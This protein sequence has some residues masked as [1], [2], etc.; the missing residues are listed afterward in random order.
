MFTPGQPTPDEKQRLRP[1]TGWRW[2]LAR[3][4]HY[5]HFTV[6]AIAQLLQHKI[7]PQGW[8]K[9]WAAFWWEHQRGKR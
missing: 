6:L 1:L 8:D 4:M 3:L 9:F 2:H 5:P 7:A